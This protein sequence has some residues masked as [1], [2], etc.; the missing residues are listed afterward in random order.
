MQK[1]M[2]SEMLLS[3]QKLFREEVQKNEEL[4]RGID[5]AKLEEEV[6]RGISHRSDQA[7]RMT[8]CKSFSV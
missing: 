8:E 7:I 5:M 1:R 4:T 3:R 2:Q 6:G